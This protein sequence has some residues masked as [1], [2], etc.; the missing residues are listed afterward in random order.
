MLSDFHKKQ[1]LRDAS[2]KTNKESEMQTL[3]E[4]SERMAIPSK[5]VRER[6]INA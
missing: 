1:K 4:G 6:A 3:Y 5:T 2:I